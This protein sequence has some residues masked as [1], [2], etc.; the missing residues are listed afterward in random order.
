MKHEFLDD[1]QSGSGKSTLVIGFVLGLVWLSLLY[2]RPGY[3]WLNGKYLVGAVCF[4]LWGTAD[5]LPRRWKR[6][7]TVLRAVVLICL[8]GVGVCFAIDLIAIF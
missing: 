1:P 7:A 2:I 5:I 6:V 4:V 3:P 8:L